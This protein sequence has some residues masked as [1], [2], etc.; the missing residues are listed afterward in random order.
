MLICHL[1]VLRVVPLLLL[2]VVAKKTSHCLCLNVCM[3][4][5]IHA[6]TH[7]CIYTYTHTRARTHM[8]TYTTHTHTHTH[9]HEHTHKHMHI[10]AQT[11]T[12]TCICYSLFTRHFPTRR[13]KSQKWSTVND[14]QENDDSQYISV[15]EKKKAKSSCVVS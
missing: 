8:H 10:Y 4:Q 13:R 3:S 11:R 12:H 14:L 2:S 6:C 7:A 1:T 5:H 9:A 15:E